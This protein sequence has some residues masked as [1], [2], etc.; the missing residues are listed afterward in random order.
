DRRGRKINERSAPFK[1]PLRR[2]NSMRCNDHDAAGITVP[3]AST[4]ENHL[5]RLNKFLAEVERN[6]KLLER[7]VLPSQLAGRRYS[8]TEIIEQVGKDSYETDIADVSTDVSNMAC[9]PG[10]YA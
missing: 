7:R 8:L 5:K 9:S 4:H 10:S 1:E 6:P 2:F 3:I